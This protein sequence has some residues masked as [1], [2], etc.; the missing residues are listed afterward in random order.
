MTKML[1][2]FGQVWAVITLVM[3]VM[4]VNAF[5]FPSDTAFADKVRLYLSSEAFVKALAEGFYYAALG[6]GIY[7]IYNRRRERKD[8]EEAKAA[9]DAKITRAN[10]EAGEKG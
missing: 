9:D 6:L 3:I 8:A 2:F 10:A 7:A 1:K 4:S 5:A